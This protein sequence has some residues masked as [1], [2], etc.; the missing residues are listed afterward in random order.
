MI[1]TCFECEKYCPIR[2]TARHRNALDCDHD[3]YNYAREK[4]RIHGDM[5]EVRPELKDFSATA[6]QAKNLIVYPLSA[7]QESGLYDVEVGDT[8]KETGE[9]L[10]RVPE[11]I[12]VTGL[13]RYWDR[14]E[15]HVEEAEPA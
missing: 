13:V 5:E 8:L 4:N 1:I 2:N 3:K 11:E 12:E 15:V 6:Y 14:V 9:R 10:P 7:I